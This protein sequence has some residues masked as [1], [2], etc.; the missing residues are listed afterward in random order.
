MKVKFVA[1]LALFSVQSFWT[2]SQ[3]F[4]T[5]P[6]VRI[7]EQTPK[8][9]NP[10][11]LGKYI[12]I[13]VNMATGIPQINIPLLE[14]KQGGMSLPVSLSYH[15]GGIKVNE[16]AGWVGMGWSLSYGV[17]TL[18]KRVNGLDDF[19]AMSAGNSSGIQQIYLNPDFSND[20]LANYTVTDVID[21]ASLSGSWNMSNLFKFR[22][23]TTRVTQ[24]VIDTEADEYFFSTPEGGGK[25]YYNQ[26]TRNFEFDSY[27]GWKIVYNSVTDG[28][29]SYTD[30][31]TGVWT[32]ISDAGIIYE[33]TKSDKY[34]NPIWE[35]PTGETYVQPAQ[36]YLCDTW[37][38]TKIREA[39]SNREMT[40]TYNTVWSTNRNGLYL[41]V[42][43]SN[44]SGTGYWYAGSFGDEA[45]RKG[46]ESVISRIDFDQGYLLFIQDAQARQD[47]GVKALKEIKL[48][49]KSNEIVKS[50]RFDY[51]YDVAE[52]NTCNYPLLF[53]NNYPYANNTFC[54]TLSKRLFLNKVDEVSYVS[55]VEIDTKTAYE[56]KYDFRKKL[57][58]RLS[59]AQDF[60]GGS[61]GK[62]SNTT[63]I[64][65]LP[66][67]IRLYGYPGVPVMANRS[68]DT[69]FLKARMIKEIIYPTGGKTIFEF[70]GNSTGANQEVGGL[71]IKK[72]VQFDSLFQKT[73]ITEYDYTDQGLSTGRITSSPVNYH[74]YSKFND[75]G[76]EGL[77]VKIESDPLNNLY[78][79][80][81]SPVLYQSV[82]K[83]QKGN[84]IDLVSKHYFT[85]YDVSQ[86][87]GF[88]PETYTNH[89][90]V[91]KSK[92]MN[93]DKFVGRE[94]KT[95]IFKTHPNDSLELLEVKEIQF[96]LV[97][98][99]TDYVWNVQGAWT[100]P[101]YFGA[102]AM[103][104]PDN[105][106]FVQHPPNF[107]STINAY[108]LYK[109]DVVPV[110]EVS[111]YKSNGVEIQTVSKVNYDDFSKQKNI[112]KVNSEGDT[113]ITVV[114]YVTD[115]VIYP[116]S[117]HAW[118]VSLQELREANYVTT[119]IEVV[120]FIKR[121]N[122]SDSS[123][124]T[125]SLY[126]YQNLVLKRIYQIDVNQP[127]SSFQFASNGSTSFTYDSKYELLSEIELYDSKKNPL[128]I[129]KRGIRYSNLWGY[130][131]E[132]PVSGIANAKSTEVLHDNFEELTGW[133]G[134]LTAYDKTR[135]K[136]G[137]YSGRIDKLDAGE[138]VCHS[139]KWTTISLS[140]TKKFKYSVWVYSTGPTAE[141]FLFMRRASDPQFGYSSYDQVGTSQTNQWVLL[142]KEVDVPADVVQLNI[143]VDN[144]GGGKVWFDDVRLLPSD[145]T[146]T[147]YTYNPLVGMTSQTDANNR[148]AFYE[149]DSF[150][151][152]SVIRD[153]DGKI[154]KKLC[155]NYAGQAEECN[156]F[157]N[158]AKSGNFT[159]N[160]SSGQ[161]SE[162][163]TYT[164]PAATYSAETQAG[165]NALAQN[166][167]NTNGQAYANQVGTCVYGSVS[168]SGNYYSAVCGSGEVPEPIYVNVPAN[169]FTSSVSQA[170]ANS[171]ALAY[172]Q[173]YANTNGICSANANI[174]GQN[175]V[176]DDV[177]IILTN[178]STYQQYYL[179][180]SPFAGYGQIGSVPP[181]NYD[182]EMGP[183]GFSY[184]SYSAG[185]SNYSSGYVGFFYN[186]TINSSCNSF[187]FY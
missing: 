166:D 173:N 145:A 88:Y 120:Q 66:E 58:S 3:S 169:M 46:Q 159:R 2:K 9:P 41:M 42:D 17:G 18:V 112:R 43:Y 160:C 50:Y 29:Y 109:N 83:K 106:P 57:P 79:A 146:M 126:E 12:D 130:S 176:G 90:G 125:S 181:G 182:V 78:A 123:I 97:K 102:F 60:W 20:T 22:R 86:Y 76:T 144:N 163:V 165:A 167:V 23:F 139:T 147:T 21:S 44:P 170:A 99:M 13:P 171:L 131:D 64:A 124:V 69:A 72:I 115:Y 5:P 31:G 87:Y 105:D 151:R 11:S 129:N 174:Y 89:A 52:S 39:H 37:H 51:F 93:L 63:L 178:T 25:F 75:M 68:V 53:G 177:Y 154:I 4:V 186:I 175:D 142:Q 7:S 49:N 59:F 95:E 180:M 119:P 61:N 45:I 91:P 185:C 6:S 27:K 10:A 38:L 47:G 54:D 122:Q 132:Y 36:Q 1:L 149:Y 19:S 116:N 108:K 24:G 111:K 81:N 73:L 71:R 92:Q 141:I 55:N 94:Y 98:P 84:N 172:A 152:L 150:N 104:W 70:E 168:Y 56:F 96:S 118:N 134:S 158:V 156:I 14:I 77:H 162:T 161:Q 187:N 117:T 82:L 155:Y 101:H 153:Q 103:P 184:I 183:S 136:T 48:Y 164:V 137:K 138:L 135:S 74:E 65:T 8:A 80:N 140:A 127:T 32:I 62:T 40:F 33:Y 179:Y 16:S 110:G 128:T 157:Y 34:L 35:K 107:G 133:D 121:K 114:K 26:K 67:P 30:D 148:S 85:D 15:A 143:R 28:N 113:A 100:D